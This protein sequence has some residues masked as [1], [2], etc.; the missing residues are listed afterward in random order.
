MP[1]L[2]HEGLRLHY[3]LR[4]GPPDGGGPVLLIHG[5]GS[6]TEDWQF[7]IE[8]L[9]ELRP[10]AAIDLPGFGQSQG[11]HSWPRIADYADAARALCADL[12]RRPAHIIGLSL[13]GV[14]GLHLAASAAEGVES[15]IAAGTP[16][17]L[18]LTP[19]GWLWGSARLA[20][21]WLGRMDW[22]AR[23]VSRDLFPRDDQRGLRAEGE[24][25]LARNNRMHYL[26]AVV[27]LARARGAIRVD[28]IRRPVLFIAGGADRTVPAAGQAEL[29]RR[30]PGARFVDIPGSGHATPVDSPELF[31]RVVLDFLDDMESPEVESRDRRRAPAIA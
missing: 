16:M 11:F 5:L 28:R 21:V 18:R 3:A 17:G 15:L 27:A 24:R 14:V 10:V 30:I 13:G 31:N 20:A 25:R 4:E 7:Q 22:V 26:R 2:V 6:S 23:L 29:A 1:T 9:A 8:A 12:W 19:R